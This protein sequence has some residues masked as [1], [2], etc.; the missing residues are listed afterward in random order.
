[1][2][3]VN[4]SALVQQE[5]FDLRLPAYAVLPR[6]WDDGEVNLQQYVR[7]LSAKDDRQAS[8]WAYYRSLP[9]D[10]T[11]LTPG[12]RKMIDSCRIAS[13]HGLEWIWC[14][15]CCIDNTSSSE[16]SESINSMF[17]WL[18]KAEACYAFISDFDS[19]SGHSNLDSCRWFTRG[20]T[21][22]ELLAPPKVEFYDRQLRCSGDRLELAARISHTTGIPVGYLTGEPQITE[23]CIAQRKFWASRRETTREGDVAYSLLGIFN[24]Q[25]PLLYGEGT[26]A[27]AKLQ[28]QI[29]VETRDETIFAWT[30]FDRRSYIRDPLNFSMLAE[31]PRNFG[32][33]GDIIRVD[34]RPVR[35]PPVFTNQGLELAV[36]NYIGHSWIDFLKPSPP[37]RLQTPIACVT[38]AGKTAGKQLVVTLMRPSADLWVR[39]RLPPATHE[40]AHTAGF[41]L[42]P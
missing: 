20:W 19:A 16:L 21:Y 2:R 8:I 41:L 14:D 30:V 10:S 37:D 35:P 9:R 6:T 17:H 36:P 29:R 13:S 28:K 4:T 23:A 1:M 33:A 22:Q 42:Y 31:S 27:F 25:L 24:V 34:M 39:A 12:W 7:D 18:Q 5:F 38:R 26:K 40:I 32:Q 3:L 15:M 11:L